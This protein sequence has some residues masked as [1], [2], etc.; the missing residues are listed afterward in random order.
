MAQTTRAVAIVTGETGDTLTD[1]TVGWTTTNGAVATVSPDGTVLGVGAGSATIVAQTEGKS[2][3]AAVTVL[4][5]VATGI[6]DIGRFLSSCPTSD[7]AYARIRR[8]FELRQD[9]V[10]I[11]A[12]FQCTDPYPAV[13]VAQLTDELIALQVLRTAY[14]MSA[15]T[16]GRLPWTAKSLYGWMTSNVAGVNFK[17]APGQLYCCDWIGGKRY[18]ATSR[19]DSTQREIFRD[20][21]GIAIRLD[22]YAHEI[23]HADPG[24]PGHTTG[25]AAFPLPTDPLACDATYDLANLGSYGVQYWLEAGWATGYLNIGI[26]CQPANTAQE[27]ASWNASAANG[28]RSRF[29]T[30]VPLAVT[31]SAPYGGPCLSP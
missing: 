23:R 15:G 25:C 8:D 7:T 28:S 6:E 3:S 19:Q 20:W 13:P 4:P 26:G 22:F 21:K 24:A 27:Y 5:Q 2:D 29:V 1:R 12:T 9:N 16:A 14:Y 31:V 17:T 18:I 30:N 10:L 11:T